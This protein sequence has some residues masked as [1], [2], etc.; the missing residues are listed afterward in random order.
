MHLSVVRSHRVSLPRSA[1]V[2]E[3]EKCSPCI[4]PHME[5][6]SPARR[7]F[8]MACYRAKEKRPCYML[9]RQTCVWSVE[10]LLQVW[11]HPNLIYSTQGEDSGLK[12]FQGEAK[13]T[14]EW[15]T[16][17]NPSIASLAF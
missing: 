16:G 17:V 14:S 3:E 11:Y 1:S 8:V 2:S 5:A 9:S 4:E 10:K 13:T 15:F 12:T 7:P 6:P